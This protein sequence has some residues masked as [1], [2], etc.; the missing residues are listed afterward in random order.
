VQ[1]RVAANAASDASYTGAVRERL[2]SE[3]VQG[4]S[5]TLQG[6]DDVHGCDGLTLGVFRVGDGIA[7]DVLKE[8]LEHAA[9]LLVDQAGD[10]LDTATT[11]QTANSR[12]GD[13]LDVI[14]QDFAM[15]LSAALAES[16][17]SFTA[18][19]HCVYRRLVE[20]E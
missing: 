14:T 11:G 7:D 12:L 13:T 17:T 16:F 18:S 19:R 3:S 1:T 5:L 6:V 2:T 4:T 8:D 15:T 20:N 10:T 9:G